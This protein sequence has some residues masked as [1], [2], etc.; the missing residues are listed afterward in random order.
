MKKQIEQRKRKR[1]LKKM[2]SQ[3]MSG[4]NDCKASLFLSGFVTL[5]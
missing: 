3:D 2:K 4:D 5:D 1:G